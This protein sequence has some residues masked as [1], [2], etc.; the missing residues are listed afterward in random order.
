MFGHSADLRASA[1]VVGS[2]LHLI[3]EVRQHLELARQI[4][5]DRGQHV[6]KVPVA[7]QHDLDVE[8]NRIRFERY[9]RRQANEARQVLD[10]DFTAGQGTFQRRPGKRFR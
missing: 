7:E 2:A 9:R 4:G 1:F 5:I 10:E 3:V 6:V 8:R